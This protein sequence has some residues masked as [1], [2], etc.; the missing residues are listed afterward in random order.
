LDSY[1]AGLK[2]FDVDV[3]S[4][5]EL[6]N[7]LSEVLT[8]VLDLC[9]IYAKYIKTKRIGE[10]MEEMIFIN[11]E[12]LASIS[13]TKTDLDGCLVKT[14][15]NMVSGED[16]ELKLAYTRFHKAVEREKG[17]VRNATLVVVDIHR[18]ESDQNHRI[19]VEKT[20]RVEN[21]LTSTYDCFLSFCHAGDL[22]SNHVF[23]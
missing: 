10:S 21:L 5:P 14:F 8:S 20:E 13:W 22:N 4:I 9:G 1:L 6:K 18:K 7:V 15:R 17:I 23:R 11:D 12:F 2:I 19:L 16:S 3:P